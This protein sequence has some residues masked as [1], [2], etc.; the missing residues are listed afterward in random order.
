MKEYERL[1]YITQLN[2]FHRWLDTHYLP[3]GAVLLW[4]RL[5]GLFNANGWPEWV[6]LD[7]R[8][9]MQWLDAGNEK[10]AYR[11]RDALV[12]AGLPEYR[13]GH[14]GCPN[15]YRLCYFPNDPRREK[16]SESESENES[17]NESKNGTEY[18]THPGS[19]NVVDDGVI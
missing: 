5:I 14:K 1:Q 18:S 2:T 6:Q 11:A 12:R 16:E 19:Q 10:T 7:A 3:A 17:K 13:K 15:R 4:F 8:R 9:I